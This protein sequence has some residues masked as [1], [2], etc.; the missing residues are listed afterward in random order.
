KLR[1]KG[2]DTRTHRRSIPVAMDD[3]AVFK[4]LATRLFATSLERE[5]PVRL[6]GFRLGDLEDPPTRQVTLQRFEEGSGQSV[7]GRED[8]SEGF[9]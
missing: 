2:F 3:P 6:V 8:R 7:H 9:E 1:Y 4:S 5:R